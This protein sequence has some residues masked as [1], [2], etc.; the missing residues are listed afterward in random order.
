MVEDAIQNLTDQKN[1]IFAIV[2]FLLISV[3]LLMLVLIFHT[4]AVRAVLHVELC[5]FLTRVS[6]IL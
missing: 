3:G 1:G 2:I 6:N 4:T 5:E